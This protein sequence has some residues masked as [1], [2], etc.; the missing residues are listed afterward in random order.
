MLKRYF[1]II[2]FLVQGASFSQIKDEPATQERRLLFYFQEPGFLVPF[3]ESELNKM[4]STSHTNGINDYYFNEVESF[5]RLKEDINL[6]SEMANIVWNQHNAKSLINLELVDKN[7]SEEIINTI[8]SYNYFLTIKTNTLGELIEFQFELFET[9]PLIDKKNKGNVRQGTLKK[10]QRVENF[11]IKPSEDNYLKE[12]KNAL[13][14]L[15]DENNNPP[16][17]IVEI[18]HQSYTENFEVYVPKGDTVHISGKKSYD[19]DTEALTYHW[20]NIPAENQYFQHI[21]K[22]N[23]LPNSPDQKI[24]ISSDSTYNLSFHVNDGINDSKSIVIKLIPTEKP[25]PITPFNQGHTSYDYLT[26]LSNHSNLGK[27]GKV[28]LDKDPLSNKN[29]I[30]ISKNKINQKFIKEIHQNDT[31]GFTFLDTLN[32]RVIRFKSDFKESKDGHLKNRQNQVFYLYQI[33]DKR[34]LSEAI[35]FT[36]NYQAR[37]IFSTR[38]G[39]S[40]TFLGDRNNWW[41]SYSTD[42]IRPLSTFSL[43]VELSADI[44][45]RIKITGFF[46]LFQRDD[47]KIDNKFISVAPKLGVALEYYYLK[48]FLDNYRIN[49]FIGFDL[50]MTTFSKENEVLISNNDSEKPL[51][52]LYLY[53]LRTG[54]EINVETKWFLL[55]PGFM[56]RV[57]KYTKTFMKDYHYTG[58]DFY[59]N[60]KF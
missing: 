23:L 14:R 46:N 44:S 53:G 48:R 37:G 24:A 40:S 2:L 39:S 21:N 49:P 58:M 52:T 19:I 42:S 27:E 18:Y 25:N 47:I 26:F 41:S 11:F 29:Q 13:H 35:Q 57:G 34:L 36:H 15:F 17:A 9:I 4:T 45:N 22:V 60:F 10:A 56:Y 30:L 8:L 59:L 51:S 12:I 6:Q 31:I 50:G 38:I 20:K 16:V 43:L 54:V 33:N 28:F 7:I 1:I 3:I 32:Y 5:N 55:S